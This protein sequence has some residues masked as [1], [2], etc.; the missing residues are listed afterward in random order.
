MPGVGAVTGA[1]VRD[2]VVGV[3]KGSVGNALGI[4]VGNV[5]YLVVGVRS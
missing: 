4:T 3:V 1:G 2:G 5:V